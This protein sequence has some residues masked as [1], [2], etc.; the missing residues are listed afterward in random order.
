M[1]KRTRIITVATM[2][3]GLVL[4]LAMLLST[5][6]P[7]SAAP[8]GRHHNNNGGKKTVVVVKKGVT[9]TITNTV[10]N[11]I[12]LTVP[13]PGPPAPFCFIAPNPIPLAVGSPFGPSNLN[14]G[15]GLASAPGDAQ[16]ELE[17]KNLNP[18]VSYKII[19]VFPCLFIEPFVNSRQVLTVPGSGTGEHIIPDIFPDLNGN[20]QITFVLERCEPGSAG[21]TVISGSDGSA[22]NV[23]ASLSTH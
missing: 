6:F 3:T 15:P 4:G 12:T 18:S 10:N 9:T 20:L 14:L 1:Q 16:A 2:L 7:A 17:C 23:P 5:L 21:V 22:V 11:T 19:S 13:P 8:A